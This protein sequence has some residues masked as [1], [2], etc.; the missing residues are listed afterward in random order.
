MRPISVLNV[1]GRIYWSV[2]QKKMSDY[3][4]DNVYIDTRVQKSFLEK[5]AGCVE[6]ASM[7]WEMLNDAKKRRKQIC[8][9]FLDLA[10]AYGSVSHNMI[11]FALAWYHVPKEMAEMLYN[12]YEGV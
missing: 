2:Y 8:G 4:I 10:N 7:N 12:Y 11:Q 9:I 1:E 3:F 6:H 5:M